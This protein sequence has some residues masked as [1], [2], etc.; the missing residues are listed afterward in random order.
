M[1]NSV[2]NAGDFTSLQKLRLA[3]LGMALVIILGMLGFVLIE[4]MKPIDALYM[5][6]ITLST[7]GFKEVTPLHT[8]GRIFVI[9]LIIFGVALVGYT[10]SVI[11]QIVL[12]GQFREIFGRRKM[13]NK[14]SKMSNHF[15]IAGYGRVGAQVAK[16]FIKKK[17][18]FVVIDRNIEGLN[19]SNKE[20]ILFIQGE[21]TDDEVL[22]R[23]RIEQAKTLISTLPD[24]AHN[25]YLAL[26]AREMNKN[27]QIIA[28]ADYEDSIK[29]LKRAGADVVVTPYLLGGIRMAMASLRPHVVDFMLSTSSGEGGLIIE[30]MVI[31]QNSQLVGKTLIESKIKDEYGL[32]IIGIKE[33]GKDMTIAPGPKTVLKEDDILVLIGH[34]DNLENLSKALTNNNNK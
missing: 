34:S 3:I 27:L 9:F 16:E 17:A 2:N 24:D 29:K 23:A 5:S 33:K 12:E 15:I 4:H 19:N 32:T 1:N 18:K 26:T 20:G 30:E 10:A 8:T 22:R 25:V 28:R 14:I 31:P 11:G 6:V 7:V 13:E 21:A